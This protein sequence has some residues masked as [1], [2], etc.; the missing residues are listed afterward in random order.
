MIALYDTL[1]LSILPTL[2]SSGQASGLH[3]SSS[4]PSPSHVVS[5]ISA[6]PPP[7]G[8]STPHFLSA[9]PGLHSPVLVLV[10]PP[11]VAEHSLHSVQQP[12]KASVVVVEAFQSI[13]QCRTTHI[14]FTKIKHCTLT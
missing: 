6:Q 4:V 7:F 11:Q 9:K 1:T 12:Y 14:F 10:P 5:E 13:E 2:Q 3:A 8:L